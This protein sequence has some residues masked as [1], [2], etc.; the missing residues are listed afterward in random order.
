[1]HAIEMALQGEALAVMVCGDE[2]EAAFASM[3]DSHGWQA[4]GIP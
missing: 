1:M 3:L 4:K 2:A